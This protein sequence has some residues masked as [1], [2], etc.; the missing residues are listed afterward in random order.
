MSTS[1]H[2]PS[3]RVLSSRLCICWIRQEYVNYAF[4]NNLGHEAA[5]VQAQHSMPPLTAI[6]KLSS[7]PV[8]P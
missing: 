1:G 5:Q 4:T 7:D 2:T 6:R 3:F 8:P